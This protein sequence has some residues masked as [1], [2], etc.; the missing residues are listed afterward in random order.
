MVV[1]VKENV[2]KNI[3]KRRAS[4]SVIRGIRFKQNQGHNKKL[5]SFS[6]QRSERRGQ[7]RDVEGQKRDVKGQK[8]DLGG[9]KRG[10]GWGSKKR[11]QGSKKRC[12]VK[13]I[14][15]GSKKRYGGSKKDGGHK[16]TGRWVKKKRSPFWWQTQRLQLQQHWILPNKSKKDFQDF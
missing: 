14:G 4:K 9:Q 11:G 8:R 13:K 1:S 12:R 7:K 15:G 3:Y 5:L 16:K 2:A 6:R 10:V